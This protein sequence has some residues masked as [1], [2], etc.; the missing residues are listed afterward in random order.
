MA[1]NRIKKA[2]HCVLTHS[3]ASLC[4]ESAVQALA[5]KYQGKQHAEHG[6]RRDPLFLAD[7]AV[8]QQLADSLILKELMNLVF[9]GNVV[10]YYLSHGVTSCVK[11]F[12]WETKPIYHTFLQNNVNN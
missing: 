6:Y 4:F 3:T 12:S 8:L 5:A 11:G 9:K 1:M 2:I 10:C 7:V